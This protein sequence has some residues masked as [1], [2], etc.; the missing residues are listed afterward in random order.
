MAPFPNLEA[1]KY[2]IFMAI[3]VVTIERTSFNPNDKKVY[4]QTSNANRSASL[5]CQK[6][7]LKKA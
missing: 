4:L 2:S 3:L 1:W 6:H 7:H 5:L